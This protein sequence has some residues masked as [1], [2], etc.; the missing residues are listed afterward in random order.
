[1]K[2]FNQAINDIENERDYQL[3]KWGPRADL[4]INR[5]NDF[6]AYIAHHSTRWFKGGFSPYSR[7]T[8]EDF[9]QQMVKVAALAVAA[10][11]S[12]DAILAGDVNRPDVL[13][14]DQ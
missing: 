2:I 4:E 9:R 13:K 1:M 14:N 8:L 7:E 6:V 10:I 11:E 3:T 5:P 12:V